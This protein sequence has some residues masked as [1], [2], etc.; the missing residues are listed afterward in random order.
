M[1][2][3]PMPK[4]SG[5]TQ[6]SLMPREEPPLAS[7]SSSPAPQLSC[8]LLPPGGPG[9]GK[10]TSSDPEGPA[11]C[12]QS[13][14]AFTSLSAVGATPCLSAYWEKG[15]ETERTGPRRQSPAREGPERGAVCGH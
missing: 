10:K 14:G 13:S 3:T 15:R 11:A 9:T 8:P 1:P 2:A 7:S 4:L 12:P 5:E 6:E